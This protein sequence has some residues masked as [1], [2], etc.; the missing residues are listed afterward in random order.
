MHSDDNT[1]RDALKALGAFA[2]TAGAMTLSGCAQ[3]QARASA[4]AQPVRWSA[5]LEMPRTRVPADATDC[6]HHIYDARYPFAPEASLRPGDGTVADYREL[7]KRIGTSRNVIVQPSSYGIDNRLLVDSL[8]QFGGRARGVAVVNPGV[9]DA[10]L[11]DMHKAGVR[12]I[13]FNLAPPGTTTLDMVGPLAARV[14]PLGW[15]VQV[16]APAVYLMEHRATWAALP[17][18]VV[19]DHLARVPKDNPLQDPTFAM[20]RTLLQQGRAYVKLSGF[21]NE[22]KVGAPSYADRVVVAGA[23]AKAAPERVLWGSDWPHPTEQPDKIPNDAI[24]LDLLAA[25]VPDETARNRILVDNP[26]RLYQFS[27][28]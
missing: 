16:N 17:C 27:T 24:L 5:G 15:H 23:F 4:M 19:F 20:V 13:R 21:Y 12:G 3:P 9:T 6:H 25:A 2:A 26:A 22:T 18:P 8:T 1:R 10:Q 7:Q 28:S 11:Q 14:A